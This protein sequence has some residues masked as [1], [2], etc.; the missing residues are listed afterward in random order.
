[1]VTSLSSSCWTFW[2][3]L[4][5]PAPTPSAWN[6]FLLGSP[7]DHSSIFY[8]S[9]AACSFFSRAFQMMVT[10]S[11]ILSLPIFSLLITFRGCPH[12]L[13]SA[14]LCVYNSLNL[15]LH[16]TLSSEWTISK[17]MA[18]QI[19]HVTVGCVISQ[20]TTSKKWKPALLLRICVSVHYI[21]SKDLGSLKIYQC[22][23]VL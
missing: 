23:S 15:L 22:P 9:L 19:I 18:H 11:E 21:Q 8:P 14:I 4:T 7:G 1:M 16:T 12:T 5:L 17:Y 2:P 13:T 10:S 3:Q 6:P 20:I